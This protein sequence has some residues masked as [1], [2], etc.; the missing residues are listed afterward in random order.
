[1]STIQGQTGTAY[2]M[3]K[4]RL[5]TNHLMASQFPQAEEVT[6]TKNPVFTLVSIFKV[7]LSER[8]CE[9]IQINLASYRYKFLKS[10]TK[11]TAGFLLIKNNICLTFIDLI[12][13]LTLKFTVTS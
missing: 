12:K 3:E 13:I 11:L 5:S 7:S 9:N 6:N 10:R 2:H 1:M 8:Q 4:R